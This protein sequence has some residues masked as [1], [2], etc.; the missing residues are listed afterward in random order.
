MCSS[1]PAFQGH[2]RS[3]E[4]TPIDRLPV[5]SYLLSTVTMGLYRTVFE[6]NADFGRNLQNYPTPVFNAPV[7]E[8]PLKFCNGS[9][10]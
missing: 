6:I 7:K 1:R 2:P 8:F 9:E 5:T 3:S 10:N 4:P